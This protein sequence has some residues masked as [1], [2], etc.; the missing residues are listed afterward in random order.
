VVEPKKFLRRCVGD[1]AAC[2][3][4]D[5]ARRK[6]QGFAQIVRNENDR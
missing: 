6:E 3:E 2:F 5:N 4:Q 1:D